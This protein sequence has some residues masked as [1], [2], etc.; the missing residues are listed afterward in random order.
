MFEP[1]KFYCMFYRIGLPSNPVALL[2]LYSEEAYD[3]RYRGDGTN[4][5]PIDPNTNILENTTPF[6]RIAASLVYRSSELVN[7]KFKQAKEKQYVMLHFK[8]PRKVIPN[9]RLRN[10][11]FLKIAVKSSKI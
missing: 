11:F 6:L 3:W 10:Y 7:S 5:F 1:L 4:F 9:N 2:A 8:Q